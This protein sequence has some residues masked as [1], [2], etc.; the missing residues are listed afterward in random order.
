M[1][2]TEFRDFTAQTSPTSEPHGAAAL[3]LV[4]SLIHF[5]VARSAMTPADASEV[6]QIAF[7]AQVEMGRDRGDGAVEP[8][9]AVLLSAIAASLAIE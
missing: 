3:S 6:V 9:A 5:L 7:D 8:A 1:S 4:E 2:T